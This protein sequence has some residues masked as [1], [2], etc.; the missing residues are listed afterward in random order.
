MI[1]HRV[2]SLDFLS[3]IRRNVYCFTV[4]FSFSLPFFLSLPSLQARVSTTDFIYIYM[5]RSISISSQKC[6][7]STSLPNTTAL[8]KINAGEQLGHIGPLSD[9]TPIVSRSNTTHFD[10]TD[11]SSYFWWASL[12][13]KQKPSPS[14]LQGW[15][16]FHIWYFDQG[17]RAIDRREPATL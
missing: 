13:V 9:L 10:G 16:N 1:R 15:R 8:P 5:K 3:H 4:L 7:S 2:I 14:C 6:L 12:C 17:T 11:I